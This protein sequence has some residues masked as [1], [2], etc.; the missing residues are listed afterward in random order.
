MALLTK[1][2]TSKE[3][4]KREK[5]HIALA[6]KAAAESIVMLE[7]DDVLPIKPGKIALY[8]AGAA[9]TI[10]GGGGSGE[11]N[12][13]HAV[14][15]KEGLE[16]AGFDVTTNAW[17]DD[18]ETVYQEAM[19]KHRKNVLKRLIT[20]NFSSAVG[21]SLVYPYGRT[22][23][24]GDIKQSD[25]DTCIYVLSRQVGEGRDRLLGENEYIFSETETEHLKTLIRSYEKTVLVINT[26]GPMD[27]G[28]LD[29]E[30][31]GLSAV[32]YVSQPGMEGGNGFADVLTGKIAPSGRLAD[33]WPKTYDDIPSGDAFGTLDDDPLEADYREGIYVGYRYY[34][35]FGIEPKY[36]FGHGLSYTDFKIQTMD[37]TIKKT[38]VEAKVKVMNIGKKHA[39]KEVVQLYVSCPD[40]R[41]EQPYQVLAAFAKTDTL[42]P[43]QSQTVVLA[44]D[45][46]DL[47]GYDTEKQTRI[48]ESGE[49]VLRIGNSSRNT[50][51]EA[52]IS[53]DETAILSVHEA[54][55]T[56]TVD[57][58]PLSK[59]DAPE[60][61][62]DLPEDIL[63][64]KASAGDFDTTTHTYV[65]PE[66]EHDEKVE[67]L[68]KGLSVDDMI[69]LIIGDTMFP[70]DTAL[71]VP[72]SVGNSTSKFF[73]RGLSN[74]VFADGPAGLRLNKHSVVKKNGRVKPVEPP[75]DMLKSLP[76]FVLRWLVT[77]PDKGQSLY[78][79]ATA[80]PVESALAQSWN[81]KLLFDIGDAVGEEMESYG[82]TYWLAPAL[83]IHR[84]P[85]CGRHFEY[86]SEDPLL[87][88]QFA[89]ETVKGVESHEG[90]YATIKHFVCNNQEEERRHMSA[91][92]DERTLRDIYLRG[93]EIAVR[94]GNPSSLMTSYNKVNHE[95]VANSH[96]L[97][98][99]VLRNE[100]NYQGTIMTDWFSTMKKTACTWKAVKEGHD[101]I[102]PGGKSYKKDLRKALKKGWLDEEDL[103]RS[104]GRIL[105]QILSSGTQEEAM[106]MKEQA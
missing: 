103:K 53:L 47:A 29:E 33:T 13:R 100:W 18:Y 32:F 19:K 58:E 14:S 56:A 85:L 8:G 28:I 35:T 23:T 25:T 15:I 50:K 6:R 68:L 88:G 62:E 37:V 3:Q 42:K 92:V 60:R 61:S 1:A 90:Y 67:L 65:T 51:A 82:I 54:I 72:G 89:A 55:G 11:V 9:K 39:A 74:A 17:I 94:E 36:P 7:N 57:F 102:M 45:M 73:D 12:E 16:N 2:S 84:N 41:L 31:K 4:T 105:K 40:G 24:D 83:N 75:I 87:S 43:G 96:E 27:T 64:L 76:K 98:E 70:K 106:K 38:T 22:I 99:K 81:K 79:F 104:C 93:F 97:L 44:F 101:Y 77:T 71:T 48:L 78:Q 26:G 86:Y 52:A 20:F 34:D 46:S 80:F 69:E 63:S 10:K 5:N 91:N 95:Y 30:L 66:I 49:Y 59:K 21:E